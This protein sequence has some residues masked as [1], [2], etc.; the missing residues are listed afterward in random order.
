MNFAHVENGAV[1]RFF[2]TL[3]LRF[4]GARGLIDF[5][6]PQLAALG[7]LPVVNVSP[8]F[9]PLLTRF[10]SAPPVFTVFSDHV[11]MVIPTEPIPPAEIAARQAREALLLDPR[12][13]EL[14]DKL[15]TATA[16]QISDYVDAQVIDLPS[17]RLMFKRV[18]LVLA[19]MAR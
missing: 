12:A 16:T 2:P 3:P 18:L 10:S 9:D 14:R 7:L 17:A 4:N 11:D 8:A 5:S 19:L 15:T 1:V 13:V 6:P